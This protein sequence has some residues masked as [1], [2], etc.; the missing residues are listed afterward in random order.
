MQSR[1]PNFLGTMQNLKHLDLSHANFKG[2]LFDNLGN[3]SLLESLYLSGNGLYVNNLKWL[4]GL[5]SLKILDLSNVDLSN[6][7]NDWFYDI[8]IILHSLETLRLSG[9]RLDRLPKSPQPE[10]NCDSLVN[11]DLSV[12]YFDSTILNWLFENCHHLQNLNLSRNYLHGLVP[13]SIE[14]MA[15]LVTLDIS[16]NILIGSIPESIGSLVSLVT[17]NLSFN[18]FNGSI[19]SS[20]G[21]TNGQ[22]SLKELCLSNNQLNGSLEK[23]IHQLS[24]FQT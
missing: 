10:L 23:S 6:C 18:M 24:K 11:L 9:C 15:S 1:V 16:H 8:N 12:N 17:L 20:L 4:H 19:P 5:S 14:R 2:G 21:Q 22:N 3:L 13:Y 7:E